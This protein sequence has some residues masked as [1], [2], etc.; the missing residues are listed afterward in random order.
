MPHIIVN[1]RLQEQ[2]SLLV[3][4]DNRGLRYGDGLFET[5]KFAHGSLIL[6]DAHVMRLW[7]GMQAMKFDIPTLLTP[8]VLISDTLKLLKKNKLDYARVR[9]MMIRNN[10]GLFDP[11]NLRPTYIIQAWPLQPQQSLNVNGLHLCIY[12]EARKSTDAFA[13]LKHNNYL[14]YLMGALHA[15]SEKCNDALILNQQGR[16][17]DSCIAN[18]FALIDGRWHTP[19][20]QEGCVAGVMRQFIIASMQELGHDISE[21]RI[22]PGMLQDASEV[23]LS[24]SIY[25]MRWVARI[26]DY[27][28]GQQ[29]IM[30]LHQQ[31][32]QT[33]PDVFC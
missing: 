32:R 21:S 29:A 33:K 11:E 20:L 19:A 2:D 16:I 30:A 27:S 26:G 31:L 7:A 18:I 8:D 12:P 10:G 25:N 4:A 3:G 5:I 6:A 22:E 1:G 23:F 17:A 14:P 13:N 9:W 15:R 28:Y 24:N